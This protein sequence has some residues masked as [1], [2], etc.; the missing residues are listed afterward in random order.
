MRSPDLPAD[1]WAVIFTSQ[2]TS[3]HGEA[4]AVVAAQMQEMAS[5]QPGFLG[6]ESARST[7]GSGITV[8]YWLTEA[9]LM[10][11]KQ[12]AEHLDAQQQGREV[13]YTS[14][15]TRIARVGRHYEWRQGALGGDTIR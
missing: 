9:H 5:V 13:F 8:S 14:Y 6:I 4:Y 2:R 11:W 1:Y 7:D 15:N 3:E 10:A 12:V